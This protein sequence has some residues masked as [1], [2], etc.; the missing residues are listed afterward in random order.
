MKRT[1]TFISDPGHGWLSVSIKEV[2]AL[3]IEN[4]I[5]GYSYMTTTRVYLEEDCDAQVFIDAAKAAGWELTIKETWMNR[6]AACR[7]YGGY[8]PEFIMNPIKVNDL[9]NIHG[10]SAQ[11]KVIALCGTGLIVQSP[12][13]SQYGIPGPNIFKHISGR[14]QRQTLAA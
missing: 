1:V 3:A 13:G 8:N 12:T 9:V 6:Q 10:D 4:K 2:I 5:S 11:F 14:I 7:N